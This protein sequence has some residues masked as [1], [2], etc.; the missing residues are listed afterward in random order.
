MK[1][2]FKN[3]LFFA[4]RPL[5]QP[6]AGRASILMY[7]SVSN[8]RHY[9]WA[10]SP[11]HFH[12]HMRYLTRGGFH[13]VPLAELASHI[14]SG[15]P[16]PHKAVSLTFDDGYRDNLTKVL[17]ALVKYGFPATIFVTTGMIGKT[18]T[19]G[20]KRLSEKDLRQLHATGLID[21]E[22]HTVTHPQLSRCASDI[23]ERE[24][25][26]SKRMLEE[27]LGKSCTLFAYPYGD[28]NDAVHRAVVQAGFSAAVTARAGTAGH[29]D[30][31]FL[32]RRNAV[33]SETTMIQFSGKLS[34]ATDV[35]EHIRTYARTLLRDGSLSC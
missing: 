25:V 33:D 34:R 16:L 32:L 30:D 2:F 3:A 7:H 9:F 5:A 22:P 18:D 20:L 10:V 14:A 29:G 31:V 11:E 6:L 17:P 4:L 26:D 35:Y 19:R 12:E 28:Y 21:I 1:S 8:P 27:L 13:V 15:T 24:I 23:L